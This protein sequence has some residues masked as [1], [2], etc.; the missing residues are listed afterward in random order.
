MKFDDS[1]P[2][3]TFVGFWTA[4]PRDGD[5]GEPLRAFWLRVAAFA[6][7]LMMPAFAFPARA[8]SDDTRS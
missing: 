3:F 2:V 7:G 6:K 4:E 8:F 1:D 5:G